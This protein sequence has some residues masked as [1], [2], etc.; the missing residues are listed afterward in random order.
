MNKEEHDQ[1]LQR[2]VKAVINYK[3]GETVGD[4]PKA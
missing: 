2:N 4:K 3:K 1:F